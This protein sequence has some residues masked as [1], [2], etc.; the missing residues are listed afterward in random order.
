[1]SLNSKIRI[2]ITDDH[3]LFRK[4]L[5]D[6]LIYEND[7]DVVF[8]TA[9][10][11]ELIYNLSTNPVDVILLDIRMPVMSGHEAMKIIKNKYPQIKIIIVS[12]DNDIAFI[13]NSFEHGASAHLPKTCDIEDLLDAIQMTHRQGYYFTDDFPK[14]MINKIVNKKSVARIVPDFIIS[15]REKEIIRLICLEKSS[16]EIADELEIAERT[17]QNHRYHISKKIGTSSS[18]GMLVYALLNG[19]ATITAEGKVVFD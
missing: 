15:E 5:A 4:T 9:N 7:L 1:M 2:A 10:G 19:I 12:M 17:V 8:D 18:V 3:N 11:A 16:K 6:S 13:E 14:E